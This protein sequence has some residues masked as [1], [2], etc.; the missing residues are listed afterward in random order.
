MNELKAAGL[1]AWLPNTTDQDDNFWGVR[2]WPNTMHGPK[3][4]LESLLCS[5][6]DEVELRV[7]AF[8]QMVVNTMNAGYNTIIN[9][10]NE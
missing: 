9:S 3:T 8:Y 7:G 5:A 4:E 6:D 2:R 1:S 10:F